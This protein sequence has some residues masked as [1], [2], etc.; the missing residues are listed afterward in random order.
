MFTINKS[1]ETISKTFRIPKR[2]V[3]KMELLA[4]EKNLSLSKV[5]VQCVEYALQNLDEEK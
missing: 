2:L 4:D 1:D 3:D 5:L